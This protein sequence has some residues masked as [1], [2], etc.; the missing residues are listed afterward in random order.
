VSGARDVDAW[1]L[2]G[3]SGEVLAVYVDGVELARGDWAAR[4]ARVNLRT[5][6]AV[7]PARRGETLAEALVW[8]GRYPPRPAV[9]ALVR[10]CAGTD[11]VDARPAA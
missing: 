6:V 7:A 8:V 10:R 5:P 9:T 4:G 11:V 2:P 1:D 3:E